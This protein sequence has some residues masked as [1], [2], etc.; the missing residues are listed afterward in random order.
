MREED[1]DTSRTIF[2]TQSPNPVFAHQAFIGP[3]SLDHPGVVFPYFKRMIAGDIDIIMRAVSEVFD[4]VL[5]TD[6]IEA[7]G[8][9]SKLRE[10][11]GSVINSNAGHE[12]AHM[13]FGI[14][15]AVNSSSVMQLCITQRRYCGFVLYGDGISVATTVGAVS[16][17]TPEAVKQQVSLL[18]THHRALLRLRELLS[19]MTLNEK[20]RSTLD[21]G[22]EVS[23][24]SFSVESIRTPRLVWNEIRTRLDSA[25]TDELSEI[26]TLVDGLSFEEDEVPAALEFNK[27]NLEL[28]V[29]LIR[30]QTLPPNDTFFHLDAQTA[31]SGDTFTG[32]L[33]LFGATAPSYMIGQGKKV[34]IPSVD[35]SDWALQEIEI[36]KT[37]DGKIVKE[38]EKKLPVVY[39]E[40]K[41]ILQAVADWKDM[42][43]RGAILQPASQLARKATSRYKVHRGDMLMGIWKPLRVFSSKAGEG[44]AASGDIGLGERPVLNE[45]AMEAFDL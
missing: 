13:S 14:L 8:M 18:S 19:D 12:L 21:S 40:R 4:V 20:E 34:P 5:S 44:A 37:V 41:P 1:I 43:L 32:I 3:N 35:K 33:A 24:R 36:Q 30:R 23:T 42:I 29:D 16:S 26:K 25:N 7:A 2:A 45:D 39:T 22:E 31:L 6:G 38:K 17:D 15:Q 9:I 11:L 28:V 10:D 27:E